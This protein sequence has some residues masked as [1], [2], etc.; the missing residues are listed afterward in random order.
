MAVF[1]QVAVP[2]EHVMAVYRLLLD[3]EEQPKDA[4]TTMARVK[5]TARTVRTA[6]SGRVDLT[7]AP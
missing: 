7:Y 5:S 2:E 4:A 1:V 3:L 6:E